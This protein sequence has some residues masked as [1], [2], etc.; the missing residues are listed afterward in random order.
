MSLAIHKHLSLLF[1]CSALTALLP[2][3]LLLH[4]P[5]A[6]A[7]EDSSNLI[8]REQEYK[9]ILK[10]LGNAEKLKN[11]GQY[12]AATELYKK[13]RLWAE[14]NL[15]KN[16]PD[17]AGI[18]N[19]LATLYTEQGQYKTAEPLFQMALL[20]YEQQPSVD[21]HL[22]AII[23][24]NLASLYQKQALYRKA[25]ELYLR[26]HSIK[27]ELLGPVHTSVATSLNN[28]A[29]VYKAQGLYS[30]SEPLYEKALSIHEQTLGPNHP[31]TANSLNNLASIYHELGLYDQ[32][33][34]LYLRSLSIQQKALRKDHPDIAISLN[35][36]ASLYED[37]GL[38]SK[39]EPLYEQALLITK[40]AL[41][42]DHPS[43]S[44]RLNSLGMIY[45][46]Q[47][48]YDKAKSHYQ[49]A[50]SIR[51]TALGPDHPSTAKSLNNLAS[52]YY[53]IGRYAE[54]EM[55]YL[56]ALSITEKILGLQHP[57][58][59]VGLNNLAGVYKD[60]GRHSKAESLYQ[61]ALLI[62]DQST[63]PEHPGRDGILNNL[64][65]HYY[66]RGLLA[67]AEHY[68]LMA[69]SST[70]NVFG[71]EHPKTA[72][73]LNNLAAVYKSQGNYAKAEPLF[74]R[75]L[76]IQYDLI[77]REAPFLLRHE[78]Q[79]LISTL[80]SATEQSF[81]LAVHNANGAN[82]ALFARLNRQGLLEQIEKQQAKL[83]S[84][85]GPQQRVAA[86]LRSLTQK[87]SSLTLTAEQ[88]VA[89]RSR[90]DELEKQLYRLLPILKPHI[91]EVEEVAQALPSDSVLIEFQKYRPFDGKKIREERWGE[92]Q[93]L[94]M[95][96][97][98][99]GLIEVIDLGEA[100]LIDQT[101]RNAIED[102]EKQL[103]NAPN[104]LSRVSQLVI[105]PLIK[106]TGEATTW[107]ISP[108]AELNRLPF[109]ALPSIRQRERY[110]SD[111]VN[112]RLLTTGRELLD[113]QKPRV[114]ASSNVLVFADP[115][116]GNTEAPGF[117]ASKRRGDGDI[118]VRRSADLPDH[119]RWER[120]E[121]TAKEGEA[122]QQ[123]I[124]GELWMREQATAEAVKRTVAPKVLHLA[125]HAFYLPD[126]EKQE[127]QASS[128]L[129]NQQGSVRGE[130]RTASLQGESPLLRSGIAMAGANQP[131]ANPNDDGYLTALEVAQLDW[132]G[133]ELVVISACESGRGDIRAGEGV[134]GLKRAIAVAGARS[135]LLSLWKV[136]D[137]ATA[138]FME[139][140]YQRLKEGQ[141]KGQALAETQKEFKN[142]P[143][144]MWR[145]PYVWAAFQ[146]SGDWRPINFE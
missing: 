7:E 99:K 71:F 142:H 83:S 56:R 80:G 108:D 89:L 68:Y 36:L 136:D 23:L 48:L 41:G 43:T 75:G 11:E 146:L 21:S 122:I 54:A 45:H 92:A 67:K 9:E 111:E 8:P 57:D 100:S 51:E 118:R 31:S 32:S 28:L 72:I 106:S 16:H 97:T 81:S 73:R 18:Y 22:T 107:F 60:Q 65:T 53:E 126:Q 42:K 96:L 59:A 70:E 103:G 1:I 61:R 50:L 12:A 27:K 139:S 39:A 120:L 38:F 47:G 143:I 17:T 104:L 131:N 79:A 88:R 34:S 69:L 119:L 125:T 137:S 19:I 123:L 40:Q 101:I 6:L 95:V 46:N 85:A 14:K 55:L 135:S 91:V 37:Q 2:Y 133:T 109:A 127:P 93:Y 116:Y 20:V 3:E 94:A 110:L 13:A 66:E 87:L 76:S 33:K 10:T 26:A 117:V 128:L 130:V 58:T 124:G 62:S 78:R 77:Q 144:P 138:V 29:S 15:G 105:E 134:Y 115:S 102:I 112:L 145:D 44:N 25:Q 113:L 132:D 98:S 141:G 49:A 5:I 24:N 35:N 52:L 84:L 121:A 140:F 114:N 64:A 86:E 4:S 90:Q 74:R 129:L 63:R 30:K 82:L